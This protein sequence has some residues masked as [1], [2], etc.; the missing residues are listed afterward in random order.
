MLACK[1]KNDDSFYLILYNKM[2]SIMFL[3]ACKVFSD[4]YTGIRDKKLTQL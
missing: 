3:E 4:K 1:N 2:S